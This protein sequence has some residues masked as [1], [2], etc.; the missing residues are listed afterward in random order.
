MSENAND[1]LDGFLHE[2][3]GR[4]VYC[5][6][7]CCCNWDIDRSFGCGFRHEFHSCCFGSSFSDELAA[8]VPD[9][10]A[11]YGNHFNLDQSFGGI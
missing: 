5:C 10:L 8:N 2:K 4:F 9:L 3:G 6:S 7:C 1:A 11:L